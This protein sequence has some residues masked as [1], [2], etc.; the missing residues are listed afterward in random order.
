MRPGVQIDVLEQDRGW[1]STALTFARN[2]L[3][4]FSRIIRWM[5]A[6]LLAVAVTGFSLLGAAAVQILVTASPRR[7]QPPPGGRKAPPVSGSIRTC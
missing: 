4:S 7:R 5:L 6:L 2:A 1:D 3:V